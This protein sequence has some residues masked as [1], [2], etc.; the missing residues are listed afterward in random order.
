MCECVKEIKEL[1][2]YKESRRPSNVYELWNGVEFE[3]KV[4]LQEVPKNSDSN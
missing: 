1:T 4:S 3:V 2:G